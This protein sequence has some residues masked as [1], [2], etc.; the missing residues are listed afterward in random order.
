MTIVAK[1]RYDTTDLDFDNTGAFSIQSWIAKTSRRGEDVIE[2]MT[3]RAVDSTDDNLATEIQL[4]DNLI[5]RVDRYRENPSYATPVWLHAKRFG[6]TGERRALVKH[7]GYEPITA[8]FAAEA[9]DHAVRLQVEIVRGGYWEH[10]TNAGKATA[11]DISTLAGAFDYTAAPGTDINGD[12]ARLGIM[13]ITTSLAA[14]NYHYAWLGWRSANVHGTLTN[15]T[16]LWELE[17]GVTGTD[18]SLV[19]DATASP[20]GGGDTKVRC[21]FATQEGWFTRSSIKMDSVTA[22]HADNYGTFL[23]LLRTRLTAGATAVV[24]AR[25]NVNH[26]SDGVSVYKGPIVEIDNT[27]GWAI[28]EMGVITIPMRDLKAIPIATLA[29]SHEG[30]LTIY[31]K[32]QR[33]SGAGSLDLDCLIMMP[34]DEYYLYVSNLGAG[35]GDTAYL[36]ES[37]AGQM[38][39]VS[40]DGT[41]VQTIC[42]VSAYGAGIPPGDGRVYGVIASITK[43]HSITD[44]W[45]CATECV[46]RWRALRG[47]E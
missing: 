9:V 7:L 12:G 45:D 6:E 2:T 15:F 4:L 20:G 35:F 8:E 42:S 38:A 47:S 18:G 14:R 10:L 3:L 25:I 43:L 24:Y 13:E 17:D 46:P 11:T 34:I 26:G 1:L 36:T 40:D 27:T 23:V 30:E 31:V 41:D 16:P 22:N 28:Y 5:L 19:T 21:T 37:P 44:D 39:G 33:V 32:A 29:A